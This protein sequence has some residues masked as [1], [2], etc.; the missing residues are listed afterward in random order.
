MGL[1]HGKVSFGYCGSGK[2][3]APLS[4]SVNLMPISRKQFPIYRLAVE[5]VHPSPSESPF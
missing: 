1:S 3:A 5:M 4:V 2:E